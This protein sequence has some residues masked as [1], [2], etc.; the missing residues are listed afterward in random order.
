M[1]PT[2]RSWA[3]NGTATTRRV[4][5]ARVGDLP[6]S[7]VR[8]TTGSAAG[9]PS[10]RAALPLAVVRREVVADG[11]NSTGSPG[12]ARES[13]PRAAAV[14]SRSSDTSSCSR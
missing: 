5:G 1:A 8:S 9:G 3:S 14:A 2:T 4:V 12:R 6:E 13:K 11:A 7:S 10:R